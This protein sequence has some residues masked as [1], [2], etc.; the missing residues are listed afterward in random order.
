M[1]RRLSTAAAVARCSGGAALAAGALAVVAVAAVAPIDPVRVPGRLDVRTVV[2]PLVPA[3]AALAVPVGAAAR[4][5]SWERAA[6]RP[7]WHGRTAFVALVAVRTVALVAVVPLDRAIVA[8]NLLLFDGLALL[9]VLVVGRP[10][11]TALVAAVALTWFA[12]VDPPSTVRWWAVPLL[13]A[14]HVGAWATACLVAVV[15]AVGHAVLPPGRSPGGG[16]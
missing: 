6:T 15:G 4:F 1:R 10:T 14:D 12:G 3:L 5:R 8:R 2:W 13:P 16:S 7:Q 9:V 11:W